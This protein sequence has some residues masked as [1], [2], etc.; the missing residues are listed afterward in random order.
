[1][2]GIV[3]VHTDVNRLNACNKHRGCTYTI[4]DSELK[5][6]SSQKNIS[7]TSEVNLQQQHIGP[8]AQPTPACL[9]AFTESSEHG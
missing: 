5:A 2:F 6:D 7:S 9:T 1:M 4:R 3:N 8:D